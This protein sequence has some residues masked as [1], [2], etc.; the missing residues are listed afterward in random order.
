MPDLGLGELVIWLVMVTVIV[1]IIVALIRIG[2]RRTP[3][4]R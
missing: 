1:A 2:F 4:N 3:R